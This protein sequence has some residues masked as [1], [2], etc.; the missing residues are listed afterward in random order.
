MLCGRK[1]LDME[2]IYLN[3]QRFADG[4]VVIETELDTKNFENGLNKIKDSSSKAGTSIKSI[5]AGLGVAKV[6]GMAM[7]QISNSID[8]AVAR[9]DTLNNFPKVMS[10]LGIA[11][12]DAEKSIEKMSDKLAGLPT[13]LD[14]GASAVQRFT[15]ANGDVQK[16]TDIFLAL[17]NAILAGGASSEIQASALEQLSQSYAKG[18][19]D[20]MEWRTAMTAMPAQL[21]QVAQAMGYVSAD[22]LGEAL[23]EGTVSMDEFMDTITKLNT[24]GVDGFASFE[25]QARN[26][27]G[28]IATAIT[29]A[30][31]QVVKGVADLI[32]GLNKGL[33]EAGLPSISEIIA[34]IGKKAKEVLDGI[35]KSL[36]TV[37]NILKTI[38]P[39]LVPIVAAIGAFKTV[40]TIISIVKSLTTTMAALNAVM[41]A[42]PI[43][44]IVA[45]I[46][47]LVAGF[48]MLW[49][50]SEG[51]RNFWI[52]LW[53][54]IKNIVS[55]AIEGIKKFFT[56]IIDFIKNNWKN[57]LLFIVN[58]F[59]GGFKLLYDNLD[60][61]KEFVDNFVQN[62]INFFKQIPEK[63]KEFISD[64]IKF[65]AELP[66]K[67]GYFIGLIIGHILK[68]F[69]DAY[70][71]VVTEVPKIITAVIDFVKELPGK[72]WNFLVDIITKIVQ[73]GIDIAIKAKEATINFINNVINFI[74]ELP[75][76]V[77]TFLK[78]VVTKVVNWGIDLVKKGKE[79]AINLFNGIVNIIKNLPGQMLNIG[80][81]LVKGI[82]NGITNTLDWILDKIKGFGKSILKGIKKVFGIESPSKLMRDEVGKYLA[83]GIGVGFE[84]E[85]DSVYKD[86]QNA[87]DTETNKMTSNIEIGNANRNIQ[88]MLTA[89]A[90]FDGI[91]PL[92]VDLDGETIYDNQQKISARKN[93]QY[94]GAR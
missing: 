70:N 31:T 79:A 60:G 19:P 47:A 87:L 85:L 63:V 52:G 41:L 33:A 43:G 30:K 21:K 56:G 40:T 64:T 17:N 49:K 66:E 25:E 35:A 67:I 10:N 5:V 7:N 13:T 37:I 92:Q 51:F 18:K 89:S 12:E 29:V 24:E 83:E 6:V 9:V 59:A 1:E 68:F 73:W 71:W 44:L 54:G 88:Q 22:E 69:V 58:P 39:V 72:I 15:S 32:E 36:P 23:R 61:F 93:L 38:A 65:F 84:D 45:A 78:D 76:K 28:G 2:R 80:K 34:N 81:N 53:D 14:Q 42:N 46:A 16:S 77:W 50:K 48:V 20:M 3:I 90:S 27:T 82:W 55:G 91:I 11:S 8:G 86:M 57:I 26:S 4:K 94:G 62:V 75:G 74:K